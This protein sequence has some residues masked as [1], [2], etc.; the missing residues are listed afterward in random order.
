MKIIITSLS[1]L[2]ILMLP[3]CVSVGKI[4]RHD[5]DSGFYKLKTPG[6]APTRVYTNVIE[7]SIVVYP[8]IV[9]GNKE[10]PNASS[11]MGTRISRIK[12]DN[13]FYNSCF[14][15]NSVD[16]DL[17]SILFKYRHPRDDVPGQFSADLNFAIYMGFRKDFYKVASSVPPLQEEKSFIRQF[18]F[19]L[20]IF[21][22][23]GTSPVNPTVTNNIISQQYDAMVFQKGVAGFISI[24]NMSLGLAVGFDNLLDKGKSSWIYT[25]KPYLGLIISVSNF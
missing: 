12:T 2:V 25:Q 16:V 6:A 18:G 9:S 13:Y 21:A 20:G 14:I 10:F 4:A 3:G 23:I 17:T 19:D 15:S 24:G 5:F 11:G 7:D 1:V 8:V 22:G